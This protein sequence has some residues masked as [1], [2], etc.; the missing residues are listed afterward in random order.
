MPQG[1]RPSGRDRGRE[2][3][4]LA[5]CA[6]NAGWRR[7][8]VARLDAYAYAHG[9]GGFLTLGLPRLLG[10]LREEALDLGGWAALTVQAAELGDLAEIDR[11]R[12]ERQLAKVASHGALAYSELDRAA[13]PLERGRGR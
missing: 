7:G 5:G 2:E 10:E 12:L 13:A 11:R 3:R 9:E 1:R 8:V 4:F 6:A